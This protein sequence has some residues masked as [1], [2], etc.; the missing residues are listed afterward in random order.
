MQ[1][2]PNS[3]WF[4]EA[5]KLAQ[6]RKLKKSGNA[7]ALTSYQNKALSEREAWQFIG[8][9][10]VKILSYDPSKSRVNVEMTTEGRL[11]GTRWLLDVD[12]LVQSRRAGP[13]YCGPYSFTL[14]F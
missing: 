11:Q 5:A 12:A 2:K 1:V 7:K 3:I 13:V 10:I 9:L 6:W 4:E 8:P 14:Y